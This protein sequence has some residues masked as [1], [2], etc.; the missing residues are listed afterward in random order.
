MK[1]KKNSKYNILNIIQTGSWRSGLGFNAL[2]HAHRPDLVNW[3]ELQ[4]NKNI[5][6]LNYAFDVA[7][8]ELGIPRLLDA[9]DVDTARP[10]EK[11][12]ITYVASYYHTFARMKNE[13]KSGKRIANV[14]SLLKF[15]SI[16]ME[17]IMKQNILKI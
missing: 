2:I 4:Q 7:N 3:S 8:S 12:I 5:D 17:R 13:I 6:N 16:Y 11:S 10:D 1:Y 15:Y 9:E 14:R